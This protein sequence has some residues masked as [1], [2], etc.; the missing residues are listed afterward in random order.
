MKNILIIVSNTCQCSPTFFIR[1]PFIRITSRPAIDK[2]LSLV[3]V[4][5]HY[6]YFI[7]KKWVNNWSFLVAYSP[8]IK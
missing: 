3:H 6:F 4:P 8:S 5:L 7:R 1:N 2:N